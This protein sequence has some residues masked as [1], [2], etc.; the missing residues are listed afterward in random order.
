[1]A[2]RHEKARD[3]SRADLDLSEEKRSDA[4]LLYFECF[5]GIAAN[6]NTFKT[7][8]VR[9]PTFS[10]RRKNLSEVILREHLTVEISFISAQSCGLKIEIYAA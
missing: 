4:D 6:L 8:L 3:G 5:Q 2:V 10:M 7:Q 9:R 1:M